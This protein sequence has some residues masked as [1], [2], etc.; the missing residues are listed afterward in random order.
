MA[1][2]PKGFRGAGVAAGIKS[3]GNRD[4]ALIVNDGPQILEL[5]CLLPIE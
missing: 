5:R 1:S 4:L 2:L 3:S